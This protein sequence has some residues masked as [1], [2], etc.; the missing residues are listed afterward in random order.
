VVLGRPVFFVDDDPVANL[1]LRRTPLV[2]VAHKLGFKDVSFQYEPVP[3]TVTSRAS[4][5][6]S[7]C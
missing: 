2:A 7:W 6:K 1:E 5:R 4:V 3:L